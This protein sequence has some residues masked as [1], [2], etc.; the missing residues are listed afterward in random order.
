[1][2]IEVNLLL[3]A[4][5]ILVWIVYVINGDKKSHCQYPLF[6][7]FD[8]RVIVFII[9]GIIFSLIWGGIFWW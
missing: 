5:I 7:E 8:I 1:M 2:K 9:G 6:T 3:Y 4:A